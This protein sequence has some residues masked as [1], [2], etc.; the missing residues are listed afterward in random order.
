LNLSSKSPQSKKKGND[1]ENED[2]KR[3]LLFRAILRGF[4][5]K[6]KE[7]EDL[8][9]GGQPRLKSINSLEKANLASNTSINKKR[10]VFYRKL[11]K[12]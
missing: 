12:T 10:K 11:S 8:S 7:K 9:L 5:L 2:Q 3:K 4:K 1:Q 6:N